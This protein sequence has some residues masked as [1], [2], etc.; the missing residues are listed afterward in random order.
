MV[1]TV[2]VLA[3]ISE[4][5]LCDEVDR[6][7]AAAGVRVIHADP[8]A[9]L[10][11]RTWAAARAVILDGSTALSHSAE[12]LLR[13]S[14]VFVVASG[15]AGDAQFGVELLTAAIA[16]G[17]QDVF[18]LPCQAA[19]LVRALSCTDDSA[20]TASGRGRVAAV[21]GGRGG[22]GASLLSAAMALSATGSLLV[23]LD[24][25][26][27]GI[28]L[29]IGGETAGGLRWPDIAV[30][31]GRLSW[32][33]VREALPR[34]RGISVL[35]AS[36]SGLE[37]APAPV[38][39]VIDAARLGGATVICDMP[40]Q[41]T[42]AVRST[43]HGA[44]LVIVVA[45]CDV[46]CCAATAALV[47]ALTTVNPNVGLVVRGPAP[48]GLRSSELADVVGLPLLAVMR[49]E[50]MLAEKLERRGLRLGAKSPLGAAARQVL[51]VLRNS[52][53]TAQERAA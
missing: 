53:M 43:L 32:T 2:G 52:P 49:A 50:P 28:D 19:E 15:G 42:D 23:D 40:R 44:D 37:I 16:I 30:Q 20:S 22:A 47:P 25:W 5:A 8:A 35:S 26:G 11:P 18:S 31:D 10:T 27:G 21:I 33:A 14:G 9:P 1:I 6:I 48:G 7:G 46:R 29:V 39:A 51:A 3:L 45:S 12:G 34:H 4:V 36:R 41:L 38:D 13:R 24:R 17:A